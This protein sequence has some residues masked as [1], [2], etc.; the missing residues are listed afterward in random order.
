ME[1]ESRRNVAEWIRAER[2]GSAEQG[3]RAFAAVAQEWGWADVPAGLAARIA[4]AGMAAAQP[5]GVWSSWW[6]RAGVAASLAS[7][8]M[9]LAGQPPDA[10]GSMALGSIQLVAAG[11]G[12]TL[13]AARA[14]L[15]A[16]GS[17]AVPLSRA[18]AGLNDALMAPAPLCV[19]AVN[20]AV[21][22]AALAALRR[23]L[24]VD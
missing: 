6:T 21:A 18:A 14:W 22:A 5:A 24:R 2:D 10:L 23:L 8:G 12:Q 16:V 17:V 20:V 4:G 1:Q 19:L 15:E 7:V 11:V 13:L 3:D 9:V